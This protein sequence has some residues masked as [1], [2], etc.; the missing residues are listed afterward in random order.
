MERLSITEYPGLLLTWYLADGAVGGAGERH[1]VLAAEGD[2]GVQGG[3]A[4]LQPAVRQDSRRAAVDLCTKIQK[5]QLKIY[6]ISPAFLVI[7]ADMK[8]IFEV[9][10]SVQ[11]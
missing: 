7:A 10:V 9:L 3:P 8:R 4:A 6:I 2:H 1:A 11:S 5:L